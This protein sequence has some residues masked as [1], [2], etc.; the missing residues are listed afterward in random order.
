MR[1]VEALFP[2]AGDTGRAEFWAGLRPATPGNVPLIGKTRLPNLYLN[3]G[4]GTL[5]WTLACGSGRSV[6]R[7]ISGL[8]PEVEFAFMGADIA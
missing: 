5:G 2:G 4:H 8:K 1:R 7:I 6:A 3:T